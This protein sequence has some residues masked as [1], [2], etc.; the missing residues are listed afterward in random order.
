MTLVFLWL[1]LVTAIAIAALATS[2]VVLSRLPRQPRSY[3]GP[4]QHQPQ[5]PGTNPW[6]Y[7]PQS[8]GAAP[9]PGPGATT[10][11]PRPGNDAPAPTRP[12]NFV[13]PPPDPEATTWQPRPGN[14]APAPTRPV[15]FA[16]PPPDS[17]ATTWEPGRRCAELNITD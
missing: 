3:S 12:V 8:P 14:D 5:Q 13:P 9:P 1:L 4:I 15:N 2:L 6:G 17:E 16:P 7:G 10:W 11:Q